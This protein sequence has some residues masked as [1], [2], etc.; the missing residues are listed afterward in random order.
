MHDFADLEEV[1]RVLESL[2]SREPDALVAPLERG[3]WVQLL[4]GPFEDSAAPEAGAVRA[5]LEDRGVLEE[6]IA[7]LEREVAEMRREL[8]SFRRQ[9]E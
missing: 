1:E 4:G 3:R 8:E 6:R 5:P 9:F 7:A 2:Q